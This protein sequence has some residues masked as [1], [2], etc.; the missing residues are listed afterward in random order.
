ME[1]EGEEL[2]KQDNKIYGLYYTEDGQLID[3]GTVE[4]ED[5]NPYYG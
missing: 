1:K 2:E 3:Q 4:V 5:V